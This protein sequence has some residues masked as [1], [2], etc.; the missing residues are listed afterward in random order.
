MSVKL[1]TSSVITD[2]RVIINHVAYTLNPSG[3]SYIANFVLP[4]VSTALTI[5]VDHAD[6]TTN[7]SSYQLNVEGA[8][9]AYELKNNTEVPV[10]GTMITVYQINGGRRTAWD[11]SA[12]N[13]TNPIIVGDNGA[14][15]FYVPNGTYIVIASHAGYQEGTSQTIQVSNHILAPSIELKPIVIAAPSVLT[16]VNAALDVVRAVPAVQV[17]TQ[18]STPVTIVL[19]ATSTVVL[20]SS[21]SLLPYLQYL[22][23]A[24]FLFFARRKRRAFGIVYN[25]GTKLPVDLAIIRL[26]SSPAHKLIRTVVTDQKGQYLL[27]IAAGTYTLEVIKPGFTFPS[28]IL[29]GKKD[30]GNYLDVYTGQVLTVTDAEA[31][32]SAN[33]PLDPTVPV[34]LPTHHH[35][36]LIRLF[37]VT[38]QIVA[39]SGIVLS[40]LVLIITPTIFTAIMAAIQIIV[41]LFIR[42]L[43]R[44]RK[45]KGWGIVYDAVNKK[46]VTNTVVRLFEPVYNKLIETVLTDRFGRY[47]FLVGPS[48][49]YVSYNKPGYTEKIVRPLDFSAKREPTALALDVALNSGPS[50]SSALTANPTASSAGPTTELSSA[51]L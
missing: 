50:Q 15:S 42:R 41:Y 36:R 48:Q 11:A 9:L 1:D 14:Y 16:T 51:S 24:P 12:Y 20:A 29:A 39:I 30:D 4:S 47:A 6:G 34:A 46:P 38:Q 45:P 25:A 28:A 7:T 27:A 19:A 21:F 10:S 3:D 2:A 5:E 26:F 32:I 8:G 22:F 35:A 44:V 17:A 40:L 31:T 37:R 18:I 13:S 43:A 49:Y 33:I 23:T